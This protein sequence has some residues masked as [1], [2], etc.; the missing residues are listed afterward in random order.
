MGFEPRQQ[1]VSI[2]HSS[3]ESDLF[4][5]AH[6]FNSPPTPADFFSSVPTVSSVDEMRL[7]MVYSTTF[8][9]KSVQFRGITANVL[10]GSQKTRLSV[11]SRTKRSDSLKRAE[12]PNGILANRLVARASGSGNF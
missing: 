6:R 9:E 3:R 10:F 2:S 12:V 7:L 11:L 8:L 1:L 5:S 4:D